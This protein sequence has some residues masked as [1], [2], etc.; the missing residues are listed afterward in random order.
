[1]ANRAGA[2]EAKEVRRPVGAAQR[3]YLGID[4]IAQ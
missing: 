1:V 3:E 2:I 4:Y